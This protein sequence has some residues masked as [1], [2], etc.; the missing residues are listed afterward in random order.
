VSGDAVAAIAVE[1]DPEVIDMEEADLLI[2][3]AGGK[4]ANLTHLPMER[5]SA[6]LLMLES[7][8]GLMN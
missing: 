4:E 8:Q 3:F 5:E 7:R 1:V 6:D 2:P